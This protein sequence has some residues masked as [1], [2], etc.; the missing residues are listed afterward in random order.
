MLLF[1]AERTIR[2]QLEAQVE[3][4]QGEVRRQKEFIEANAASQQGLMKRRDREAVRSHR[5][6]SVWQILYVRG[7]DA[8]WVLCTGAATTGR[9]IVARRL[10][11]SSYPC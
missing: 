4:L 6:H 9:S 2:K 5:V 11:E 7:F 3:S 8:N 10:A 1:D